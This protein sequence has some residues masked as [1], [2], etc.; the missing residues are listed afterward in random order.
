V[1][2]PE[3]ATLPP[4]PAEE[5]FRRVADAVVAIAVPEG[6]GAG[7]LLSACGLIGTSQHLVEGWSTARIRFRDGSQVRALVVR[8]YRDA[9]LAFLQLPPASVGP[10]V[11][12]VHSRLIHG[13]APAGRTPVVGETVYAIGHPLGLA[14]TLTQGIVSASER[15]IAGRN[16]LQVDAAINPGNS[17]GP[18]YDVHAELV[19]LMACSRAESQGLNFAVTS[20]EVYRRFN[21]YLE[22]RDQGARSYCSVCGA[23]SR[24]PAYCDRC[25]ALLALVDAV[26]ELERAAREEGGASAG[27]EQEPPVTEPPVTVCPVCGAASGDGAAYCVVCGATL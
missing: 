17:G 21:A 27:G 16:Y 4:L 19:G 11:A 3:T 13:R 18:L 5:I 8:S 6:E 7:V 20:E 14:Y 10:A 12:R 26:E 23:A 24:D 22:E 15:Q 9:D 25:G 2:S 1:E